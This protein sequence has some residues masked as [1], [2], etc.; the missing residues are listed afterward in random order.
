M[1]LFEGGLGS[2]GE[3]SGTMAEKHF[4]GR[5]LK[6]QERRDLKTERRALKKKLAR[7]KTGGHLRAHI[8]DEEEG[9]GERGR[10]TGSVR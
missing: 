4:Q 10:D 7:R 2:R 5:G 6:D 1:I 3:G 8:G 9:A